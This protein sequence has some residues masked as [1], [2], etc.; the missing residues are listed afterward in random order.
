[1][2][3]KNYFVNTFD[4]FKIILHNLH[5]FN[6]IVIYYICFSGLESHLGRCISL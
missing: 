5:L 6:V 1:M 2:K 4:Y 3:K